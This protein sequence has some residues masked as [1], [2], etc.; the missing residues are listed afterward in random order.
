MILEVHMS[1]NDDN[2]EERKKNQK[3]YLWF[4]Y[5]GY[6]GA[7]DTNA[8]QPVNIRAAPN[9]LDKLF[10]LFGVKEKPKNES[11]EDPKK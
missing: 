3:K 5:G 4:G 1:P 9:I 6:G 7:G 2:P 10:E 11:E 8:F